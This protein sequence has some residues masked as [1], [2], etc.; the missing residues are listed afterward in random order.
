[1]PQ[2]A[3]LSQ[4]GS[5][6]PRGDAEPTAAPSTTPP[7]VTLP[8]GAFLDSEV[9]ATD[10]RL[11]GIIALEIARGRREISYDYLA[12]AAGLSRR[13]A[14]RRVQHCCQ[15]GWLV[16]EARVDEETRGPG[17]NAY[18]LVWDNRAAGATMGRRP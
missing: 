6:K 15:R 16:S 17:A 11:L 5:I 9:T 13:H 18:A 2:S 12:E 1:M 3:L 7:T 8:S 4:R 14:M 10:L